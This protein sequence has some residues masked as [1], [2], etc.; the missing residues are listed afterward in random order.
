MGVEFEDL[1]LVDEI[2]IVYESILELSE[3]WRLL[4]HLGL[5]SW[6]CDACSLGFP[7]LSLL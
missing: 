4:A 1:A 7:A 6:S 2:W 3:G 5:S